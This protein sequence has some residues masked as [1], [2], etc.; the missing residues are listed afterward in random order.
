MLAIDPDVLD[1][2]APVERDGEIAVVVAQVENRLVVV[3]AVDPL[4]SP[5]IGSIDGRVVGDHNERT[6]DGGYCVAAADRVVLCTG[7]SGQC[8]QDDDECRDARGEACKVAHVET[9]T[10]T[11]G[12]C[13]PA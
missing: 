12:R 10:C 1:Q 8:D 13:Q 11:N 4:L 9:P 2:H 5:S 6:M 3:D 7:R